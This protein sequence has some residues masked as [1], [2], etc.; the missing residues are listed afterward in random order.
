MPLFTKARNFLRNI[1]SF[2]R[3]DVDLDHEVRSHLEMLT[4]ENLRAG[5]SPSEA[6]RAARIE[7]GGIEQLKEQVRER[8]L[9]NWLHSIFAD[10][11]Y[12][13]R[14]FGKNP[15]FTT[16]ALGIGANTA[17]F[18]VIDAV[19][20]RPLPFHDP[21]CLVAVRSIDIADPSFPIPRSWIGE[22]KAIPSRPCRFGISPASRTPAAIN[23]KAF[24]VP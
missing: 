19:L 20:L 12:G 17:L 1:F 14:Q 13:L 4:D 15:G 21:G 11:R 6:K 18:S 16:V 5:M 10:C 3:V 8:R 24:P 9:G 23:P 7:L 22:R 2:R